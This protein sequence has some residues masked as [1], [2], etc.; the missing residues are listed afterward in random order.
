MPWYFWVGVV[1]FLV[2]GLLFIRW[3]A[4]MEAEHVLPLDTP[5]AL[6]P[7]HETPIYMS[8]ADFRA[9]GWEPLNDGSGLWYLAR[10]PDT[11]R[12]TLN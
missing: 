9:L 12:S 10:Y 11:G 5:V 8:E 7:T 4:R 3:G 1:M 2:G 6:P